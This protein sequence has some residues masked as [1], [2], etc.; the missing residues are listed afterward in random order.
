MKF[1]YLYNNIDLCT[2]FKLSST[3]GKQHRGTSEGPN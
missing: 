1:V 3:N 2:Q